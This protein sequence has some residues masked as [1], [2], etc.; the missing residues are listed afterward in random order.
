MEG[1]LMNKITI[2]GNLTAD[3]TTKET[4][5]GT[6]VTS[7]TVAVA[8]KFTK[9][10]DFFRVNA[11]RSLSEICA[12]YLAKGKKVAVVG[13]LQA[14][15]FEGRDGRTRVSLEV[16]AEDVEFLS[17]KDEVKVETQNPDVSGFED[18]SSSDIPF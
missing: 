12:K 10:T 5:T 1:R 13:E 6:N 2:I 4:Q 18:I 14:R 17:P 7:F 11:W 8:R 16:N 3:P 15:T 9:E